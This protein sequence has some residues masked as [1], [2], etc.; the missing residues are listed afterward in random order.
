MKKII[1]FSV[2]FTLFFNITF[3]IGGT[4]FY[5]KAIQNIKAENFT[6]A[7]AN[8]QKAIAQEPENAVYKKELAFVQ[9]K[10]KANGEA[11]K[12]ITELIE[13]GDASSVNYARLTEMYTISK[14]YNEALQ[15]SK[16]VK[17]KDLSAPEKV[18]FFT[19][20]GNAN[21]AINYYPQAIQAWEKVLDID[22]KNKEILFATAIAYS[23]LTRFE[24]ALTYY[25]KGFAIDA[26]N[27][28][29]LF[30]AGI[31]AENAKKRSEAI[32][33]FM[34]AKEN[35][36]PDNVDFNYEVA[37]T[38]YDGKDFTNAI[39]Y[40][41]K[42]RA[43]SPYDQDIASLTAYSYYNAGDTK[44]AREVIEGMMKINP[45]NGDLVYLIG[46]TWQK[47]GNMDRAEK[48]FDR[49]FKLKPELQSLRTSKVS[50]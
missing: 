5:A 42:A 34:Q 38:Y 20:V 6:E 3:A 18:S 31:C 14:K 7:Y 35:G 9:Y 16:S 48:Y 15:Q 1:F 12:L 25:K 4:D 29:R 2:L 21:Y 11:I 10:R 44:K 13:N 45:D 41:D 49:A 37:N 43:I 27:N 8:L 32:Q 28:R 24:V 17:E 40:L 19:A 36:Y 47:E 26:N 30:E 50:F 39:I 33:F 22:E 46:M 23:D